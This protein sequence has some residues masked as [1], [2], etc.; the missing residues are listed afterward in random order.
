M[1][2]LLIITWVAGS[3]LCYLAIRKYTMKERSEQYVY[4]HGEDGYEPTLWT[5][6]DRYNAI[7]FSLVISWLG[8]L[9]ATLLN[10]QLSLGEIEDESETIERRRL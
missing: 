8:F 7:V 5:P 10:T 2:A 9:F 1:Q 3:L 4:S 6:G